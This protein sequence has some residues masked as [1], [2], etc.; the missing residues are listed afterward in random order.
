MPFTARPALVALCLALS[1]AAPASALMQVS[2]VE[3][4][5]DVVVSYS[6]GLDTTGLDLPSTSVI[7]AVAGISPLLGTFVVYSDDPI[8][9][10]QFALA[11]GDGWEP[12][13]AGGVSLATSFL[14]D[15]FGFGFEDVDDGDPRRQIVVPTGYVALTPLSGEVTFA[16]ASLGSLGLTA[17]DY[18][19]A[20]PSDFIAISIASASTAVPLPAAAP[21][22]AAGLGG[23]ALAARRRRKG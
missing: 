14:G 2:I 13:G 17:G 11:P 4:G 16:G 3:S 23:L 12:L 9:S 10:Y 21:L 19:F 7:G 1:C 22:L 20:L 8:D 6:G 5:A 18:S 15:A